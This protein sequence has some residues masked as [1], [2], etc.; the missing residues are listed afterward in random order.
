[1]VN[2][3]AFKWQCYDITMVGQSIF[4]TYWPI[5]FFKDLNVDELK[6]GNISN[7]S[8]LHVLKK[9]VVLISTHHP[10]IDNFR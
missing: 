2:T 4:I 10:D 8:M 3:L 7:P 9:E 5:R 1:M 6:F